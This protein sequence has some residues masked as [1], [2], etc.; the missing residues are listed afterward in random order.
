MSIFMTGIAAVYLV[1]AIALMLSAW[2]AP[3]L[4]FPALRF[5]KFERILHSRLYSGEYRMLEWLIAG[6]VFFTP[7]Q[8]SC[9]WKCGCR[10]N[11]R[12]QD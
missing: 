8:Y 11:G 2:K 6:V 4:D 3:V 12:P 5:S 7:S 9:F 10:L 1:S